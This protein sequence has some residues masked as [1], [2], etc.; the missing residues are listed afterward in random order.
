MEMTVAIAPQ[1][2]AAAGALAI[3]HPP[4]GATYLI[5][6]TLRPDFQALPLRARGATG[7]VEWFVNDTPVGVS[8]GEAPLAW[9]LARGSHTIQARDTNGRSASTRIIVK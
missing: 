3:H 5:D 4:A 1:R 6:P 8:L 2:R 9:P 7:R